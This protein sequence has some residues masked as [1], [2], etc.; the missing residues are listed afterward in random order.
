MAKF[1]LLPKPEKWIGGVCAG[2]GYA[3]GWHVWTIRLAF[4]LLFLV[5][6]VG[7]LPY[8]LLWLLVPRWPFV[9]DDFASRT[10]D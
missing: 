5:Y 6:G 7:I 9:P 4:V 2:L 10:G 8:A 3:L 1:R